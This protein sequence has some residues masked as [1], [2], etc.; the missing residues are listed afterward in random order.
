M[1]IMRCKDVV[2]CVVKLRADIESRGGDKYSKGSRWRVFLTHRG[3]FALEA[4]DAD[5]ATI[6]SSSGAIKHILRK[7]RREDFDIEGARN[8]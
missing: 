5:N 8:A 1:S 2:G 7:V 4:I 6:T 3:R